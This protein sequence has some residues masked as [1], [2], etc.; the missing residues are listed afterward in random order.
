MNQFRKTM[1]RSSHPQY[2]ISIQSGPG[3]VYNKK[4]NKHIHLIN[5]Q[6]C[7]LSL[8]NGKIICILNNYLKRNMYL[9]VRKCSTYGD[10]YMTTYVVMWHSSK[11]V[12]SKELRNFALVHPVCYVLN[13]ITDPLEI[14]GW[15]P[16]RQ[17]PSRRQYLEIWSLYKGPRYNGASL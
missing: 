9:V 7:F 13:C 14:T 12:M 11:R 8:I 15:S 3:L 1:E 16:N 2:R 17:C 4:L 5:M 6:I 10:I